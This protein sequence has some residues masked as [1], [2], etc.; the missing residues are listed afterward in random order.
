VPI[1]FMARQIGGAWTTLASPMTIGQLTMTL[2]S[3]AGFPV[4]D[5]AVLVEG[6]VIFI[7]NRSGV[8]CTN[9]A[10]GDNDTTPTV[11]PAGAVVTHVANRTPHRRIYYAAIGY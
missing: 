4:G 6:E 8:H 3:G 1:S 9:L 10:R 5:Y 11:H 2:V 7:G